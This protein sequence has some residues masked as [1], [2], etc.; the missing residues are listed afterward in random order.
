[1]NTKKRMWKVLVL[2]V[3]ALFLNLPIVSALEISNVRVNVISSTE[4]EVLW[5]TDE[6]ANSLVNYGLSQQGLNPVGDASNVVQHSVGLSSLAPNTTYYY[7][8]QSGSVTDDNA[9]SLYS[10]STPAPDTTPPELK[11]EIPKAVAG[12]N[13]DLS[14]TA[15]KGTTVRAYV[16][17]AQLQSTTAVGGSFT[18][19]A[20]PLESNLESMVKIEAV[21]AS[22]NTASVEG[23][24]F[25]DTSKP[26]L[27]LAL[28]PDITGDKKITLTGTI[29]EAST[30]EVFVN[31]QS[32]EKGEGIALKAEVSLDEGDNK[33]RIVITDAAGWVTEEEILIVSDTKAPTVEFDFAKGKEYYQGNAETDIS[34]TTESG[35]KVFLFIFRPLSY[36]FTPNFDKAWEEVTADEAG[37]FTFSEVNFER[38]PVS[39]KDLAPR[40]VP[41]GLQQES[42][43][44]IEQV[45]AA[46]KFTYHVYLIAEDRSGK[47]GYAKKQVTLNTC[48]S[49]DFDFDVQ[50][51]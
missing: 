28:L 18:L 39:L 26:K 21:D 44:R 11:V 27:E 13:L 7:K 14:G 50:S 36:D 38:P 20:I 40:E 16:N 5:E 6:P 1:M 51:L 22:G 23:K 17:G 37:A 19:T 34:G 35:A 33:I 31:N 10:F 47:A 42:I 45:Q 29:S 25:A 3:I 46:Q 8:V 4:A 41:A 30:F 2:L 32:I 9:G 15:E 12:N 48:Y 24:V 43:F 49:S